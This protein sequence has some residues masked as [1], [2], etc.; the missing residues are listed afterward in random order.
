MK[1]VK[2]EGWNLLRYF[3]NRR[4]VTVKADRIMGQTLVRNFDRMHNI[5][6]RGSQD[7][8][9][10]NRM[11][12]LQTDDEIQ[13]MNLPWHMGWDIQDLCKEQ[14]IPPSR[15]TVEFIL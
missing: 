4:R 12:W 3:F 14:H 10:P 5:Y 1:I 9:H 8:R 11:Y 13:F 2:H 15:V 6:L 7:L